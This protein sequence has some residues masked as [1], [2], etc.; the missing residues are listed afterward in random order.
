V[1]AGALSS[2]QLLP[3]YAL[4][5]ETERAPGSLTP[6][7]IENPLEP[8]STHAGD[9]GRTG[10]PRLPTGSGWRE[11]AQ[12]ASRGLALV[13]SLEPREV[14]ALYFGV[15]PP[16]LGIAALFG[17]RRAI[18]FA[19]SAGV[20]AAF[21]LSLGPHTPLYALYHALPT[22]AWFRNTPR[23][24]PII[25]FD[26]IAAGAGV[27]SLERGERPEARAGSLRAGIAPLISRW[28]PDSCRLVEPHEGTDPGAV[29][30][31]PSGKRRTVRWH[32]AC[33][34]GDFFF[35]YRNPFMH[36]QNH[37]EELEK[38]A[39][40]ASYLRAHVKGERIVV[41]DNRGRAGPFSRSTA[42]SVACER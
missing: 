2:P 18:W 19:V 9:P 26:G 13:W 3:T 12:K 36:P 4:S 25:S 29:P 35:S 10:T 34:C 11:G 37:P 40:I 33:W 14:P 20:G 32:W 24:A 7:W 1:T 28:G 30:A 23:S 22:G 38:H 8:V 5:R 42:C 21:I 39:E 27:R 15:L 31:I 16:L 41:A 17:F 6:R